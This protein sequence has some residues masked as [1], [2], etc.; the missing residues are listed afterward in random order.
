M[1]WFLR[2]VVIGMSLVLVEYVTSTLSPK[3]GRL[4]HSAMAHLPRNPQVLSWVAVAGFFLIA[5]GLVSCNGGSRNCLRG[6]RVGGSL[7]ESSD[8]RQDLVG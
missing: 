6:P 3:L 5:V 4:V 7:G 2:V 1:R 8:A